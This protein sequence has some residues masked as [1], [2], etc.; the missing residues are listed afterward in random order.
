MMDFV[1][2][3]NVIISMLISGR[4]TYRLMLEHY[5]FITPDYVLVEVN[6]YKDVIQAKTKMQPQALKD[7]TFFVFSNLTILPEYVL[8][9][10][11]WEK[12]QSLLADIDLKDTHYVALSMEL[13][14][15]LLTRDK[16]IHKGLRKQGYRKVVMFEDFLADI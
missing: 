16:P 15:V 8:S 7:W 14:L 2:D 9:K 3:A 6:F 4:A 11:N 10:E 5:N 13:D 1:V 12:A